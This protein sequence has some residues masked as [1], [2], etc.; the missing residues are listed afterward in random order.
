M[1]FKSTTTTT[2]TTASSSASPNSQ[3]RNIFRF[4]GDPNPRARF[5]RSSTWYGRG[6]MAD[7]SYRVSA[8]KE[9]RSIDRECPV[10]KVES[11]YQTRRLAFQGV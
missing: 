2:T 9:A 1:D 4:F 7:T 11:K 6:V 8:S 5:S 10:A 3:T